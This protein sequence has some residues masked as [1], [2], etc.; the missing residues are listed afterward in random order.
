MNFITDKNLEEN[1]FGCFISIPKK[2]KE[3]RNNENKKKNEKKMRKEKKRIK[4]D[5]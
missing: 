4:M 1:Q 5:A 2:K 3:K